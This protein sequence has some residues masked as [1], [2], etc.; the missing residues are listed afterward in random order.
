MRYRWDNPTND[1]DA[2][3]N[4]NK[5]ELL[6]ITEVATLCIEGENTATWYQECIRDQ[7]AYLSLFA[8]N[9]WENGNDG[10]GAATL[11][12]TNW[13]SIDGSNGPFRQMLDKS[14]GEWERMQDY[15]NENRPAGAP[16]IYIIPYHRM[17]ARLYDDVQAGKVPS[18]TQFS[19]F[20]GD[21]IHVNELGAYAIAMIHYACIYNKNPL[22]LP[23]NLI[24]NPPAGT[25]MPSL[26]LAEY[27]QKMIWE[28]VT[29]Y[30]RTGIKDTSVKSEDTQVN[31]NCVYPNPAINTL[32]ICQNE[33]SFKQSKVS[34]FNAF[35]KLEMVSDQLEIDVSQLTS[36]VYM[37]RIG[38][39]T[40]RFLKL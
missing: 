38:E 7:K 17:M 11:L 29:T 16:P 13:V 34:I 6:C 5:F 10:Q 33:N 40:L 28:V 9:A 12:W 39:K 22:G 8:N 32:V 23:N 15:A 4:I 35:G 37:I 21:N 18:I 24:N 27:L 36:G 26:A 25:P 14:G 2:R 31:D 3:L 1:P 30:P 20:F 19:Q